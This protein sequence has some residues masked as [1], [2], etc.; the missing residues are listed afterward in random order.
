MDRLKKPLKNSALQSSIDFN[1]DWVKP[2]NISTN[3][4]DFTASIRETVAVEMMVRYVVQTYWIEWIESMAAPS[5]AEITS[6][7]EMTCSMSSA[8]IKLLLQQL[9]SANPICRLCSSNFFGGGFGFV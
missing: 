6:G 2:T 1:T 4:Y 7:Y 3:E 8:S 9:E 5:V